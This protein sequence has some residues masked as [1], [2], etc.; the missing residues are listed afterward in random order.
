MFK[1]LF[2]I[3][4]INLIF[5]NFYI[6]TAKADI[7]KTHGDNKKIKKIVDFKRFTPIDVGVKKTIEWY[8]KN[9]IWKY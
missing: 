4:L 7:L 8:K 9:K 1:S 5:F 6:F 3:L 2:K